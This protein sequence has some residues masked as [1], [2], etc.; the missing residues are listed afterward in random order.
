LLDTLVRKQ[1]K[2]MIMATHSQ[3]VIGLADYIVRVKDS[4]L[5][6]EKVN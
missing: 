2:T 5:S 1:N 4:K 6:I 3:D